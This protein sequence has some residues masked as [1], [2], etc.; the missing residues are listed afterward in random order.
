V[1]EVTAS[2][3]SNGTRVLCDR[4][5]YRVVVKRGM[6]WIAVPGQPDRVATAVE[7]DLA[8]A[9][10]ALRELVRGEVKE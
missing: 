10:E 4:G 2:R 5:G 8:E 6:A 1:L 3:A 7:R 9:V